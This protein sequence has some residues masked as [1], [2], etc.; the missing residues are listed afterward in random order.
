V[1]RQHRGLGLGIAVLALLA[2]IPAT[3]AGDETVL[4]GSPFQGREL[5]ADKGC[6]SCHSVWGH[7]GS[8][9]P[10]IVVAVVG[11]TWFELVGDFWNHTPRMIEEVSNQGYAWPALNTTEMADI[12]SYLYYLRL[13]DN[14]GDPLRGA[15]TYVRL[16][17]A[18]C[19]NL[20]GNGGTGGGSLDD[21]GAYLT[22]APLAQAMWNAGPRMQ[23]EQLGRGRSIPQFTGNE[24]ADLQAFIRAEG[25]RPDREIKLQPLPDPL[26]GA[27]VYRGKRCGTCH[28]SGRGLAPDLT[29]SVLSRTV[30]EITGLLW[31]HSYAMSAGMAAQG[32]PFP[33]FE[34]SEF[35]DLIA[36]LYFLG[37]VSQEGDA[38]EGARVFA[39][40]GC[41]SCH[42]G[43]AEGV[44]DLSQDRELADP[45]GLAAAVW[46]HAP[47]MHSLMAEKSA[48]WPKFE[49]GEMRNLA[50]YLHNQA[51]PPTGAPP[52]P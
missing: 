5:F 28:D 16:H 46:N 4:K 37:F 15:D 51:V 2:C 14:P 38:A 6:T 30:A 13:F 40:K 41:T 32:V 11:K 49:P 27:Q 48:F 39:G 43:G 21:F 22:P 33:R 36:Y 31:N 34:D 23:K 18:D 52:A 20:A 19:H 1:S 25:F 47:Q 9:G 3:R 44:P 35:A 7:G 29:D 12:L 24:M 10:D 26:R 50:A 17:C 45:I 42:Q 8:L